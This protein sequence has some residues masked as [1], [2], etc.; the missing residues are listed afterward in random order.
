[1]TMANKGKQIPEEDL[2]MIP[3]STEGVFQERRKQTRTGNIF[4]KI[5]SFEL[6]LWGRHQS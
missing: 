2:K 5:S 1:M 6:E 4:H 3:V